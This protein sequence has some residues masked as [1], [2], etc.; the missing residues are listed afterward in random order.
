MSRF[1]KQRAQSSPGPVSSNNQSVE[2]VYLSLQRTQRGLM[3]MLTGC[4]VVGMTVLKT[5]PGSLSNRVF[6]P[7][8]LSTSLLVFAYSIRNSMVVPSLE[9]LRRNPGDPKALS[10]WSRNN[11]IVQCMCGAVGMMGFATQLLGAPTPI[12]LTLYGIAIAYLFLLR[13]AK[14]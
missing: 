10:R 2:N 6:L 13:P 3:G 7:V 9:E 1:A 5:P 11:L 14:P 8:I 4:A 12:A